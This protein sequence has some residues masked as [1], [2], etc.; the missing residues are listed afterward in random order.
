MKDHFFKI[1]SL[2][3]RRQK[4]SLVLL[5]LLLIVGMFLEVLGIGILLP[6]LTIILNPKEISVL[7]QNFTVI[8]FDSLSY[9]EMVLWSLI[10]IAF[11]YLIKAVF[12]VF[13]SYKQ[14]IIIE[15][16][17]AYLANRLYQKYLYQEYIKHIYGDLS[18]IIKNIQI[19]IG[20]FT[21]FCR[22]LLALFAEITLTLSI[23]LAI[24]Y[25]EPLGAITVGLFFGVLS[26]FYFHVTKK[27]IK[28]WGLERQRIDK[29]LTKIAMESLSGIKDV[30]LLVKESFFDKQY[31]KN[32]YKRVRV[33]SYHQTFTQLPRIYL[34]LLTVIGLILFIQLM[35]YKG[36]STTQVMTTLGVFVAA[37][38]RMIPSINRILSALQNLK[39]SSASVD[40]I[41]DEFKDQ[42]IKIEEEE[43]LTPFKFQNSITIE[44]LSFRYK[45]ENVLKQIN[46]K[47]NKGETVGIIGPSGSGK[48]TLVDLINGLLIPSE[49]VIKVD[50]ENILF[51]G[52]DWKQHIG[53][54]GQEIFLLDE[55][56][57]ANIGFGIGKKDIDYEK[58]KY[59]LK[60][61]QLNSFV[62]DLEEGINTKV[63]ERG[64]QLSGGQKQRIGIA[65]A[66][67]HKPEILIFDEATAS[68]DSKTEKELIK[69]IYNLK[70]KKTIIMV[71]HRLTTLKNCDKI[72]EIKNGKLRPIK[73][74]TFIK[75]IN[76]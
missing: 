5:T 35:F 22:A 62:D 48:S 14:S 61:A 17:S 57:L 23:L 10:S 58:V 26:F 27:K 66:L 19:E 47:I 76:D 8:S 4:K 53:Y 2:L 18:E 30:K 21:I 25:I 73:K 60:T 43:K 51:K 6:A 70:G 55:T 49:G 64:I 15:N 37:T 28:S 29:N 54:V 69:S 16:L 12:L 59:A 34:E 67:Y 1:I 71:A 33:S 44:N 31:L 39:Y 7:I 40:I 72:F 42:K 13:I 45:K 74:E 24:I 75:S 3:S 41:F 52:K 11:I 38:F 46:F 9:Q 50:E 20:Y 65:R 68:L 36:S 32:I 56:I 63:G